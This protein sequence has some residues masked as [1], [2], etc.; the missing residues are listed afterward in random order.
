M[1]CF[2]DGSASYHTY[3]LQG[4]EHRWLVRVFPYKDLHVSG[5]FANQTTSAP[6]LY[7]N[8]KVEL[9]QHPRGVPRQLPGGLVQ[10][11]SLWNPVFKSSQKG[12]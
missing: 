6:F 4:G 1:D 3:A 10:G 8:G 11:K 9:P 5:H 7:L 12:F 2:L